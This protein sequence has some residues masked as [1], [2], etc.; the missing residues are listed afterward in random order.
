MERLSRESANPLKLNA[1]V[2]I[3]RSLCF[4]A[5]QI[6]SGWCTHDPLDTCFSV[7]FF[8]NTLKQIKLIMSCHQIIFVTLT[9]F[10]TYFL[11]SPHLCSYGPYQS[12]NKY[13]R[14]CHW[15]IE[16]P[17]SWGSGGH[18]PNAIRVVVPKEES[19]PSLHF[20]STPTLLF[21]FPLLTWN[22][23]NHHPHVS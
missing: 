8:F 14:P 13:G 23:I 19:M 15:P 4:H 11:L 6:H 10:W 1:F 3:K 17:Q 9:L 7:Y 21:H 22:D 5:N 16:A 2:P 12:L 20:L 18:V